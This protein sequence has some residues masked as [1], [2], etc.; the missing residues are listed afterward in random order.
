MSKLVFLREMLGAVIC[1]ALDNDQVTEVMAN[2]DGTIWLEDRKKGV[3]QAGN[4]HPVNAKNFLMQLADYHNQYLTVENPVLEVVLPFAGERLEG[5]I[6]PITSAAAFT[7]RKKAKIVFSLANYLDENIISPAQIAFIKIA[8]RQRK[9]MLISGGPGTGKTTLTNAIV[10]EMATLCES[11]Q[12]ILVL[13]DIN[14]IQCTMSN[15]YPMLTSAH[16]DMRGLL[17]I[18]MRSRPDRILVGEV[19]DAAALD[20]LKAWNTGCPGGIAT[21]HANSAEA[22]IVRLLSLAE[23]ANVP[24]PKQ[25]VAETVDVLINIVRDGCHPSGRIVKDI[26]SVNSDLT[27]SPIMLNPPYKELSN[28]KIRVV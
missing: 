27:T 25:L 18:A 8:I 14:E 22:S 15:V 3:Y 1:S 4:I 16:M 10:A 13:E 23:E 11:S 6:P 26:V 28:E 19:R 2:P 21:L 20:L 5:T 12:R 24:P 7:I 17:R 9:N